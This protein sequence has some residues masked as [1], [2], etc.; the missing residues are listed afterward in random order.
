MSERAVE[1][2]QN[3]ASDVVSVV[4]YSIL[5]LLFVLAWVYVPA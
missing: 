4:F 3:W 5:V 2:R 1:E